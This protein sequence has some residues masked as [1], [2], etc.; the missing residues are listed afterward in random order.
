MSMIM[1]LI[2]IMI[3]MHNNKIIRKREGSKHERKGKKEFTEEIIILH[4][5]NENQDN[6]VE[7]IATMFELQFTYLFNILLKVNSKFDLKL[8]YRFCLN[9]WF[10]VA[11]I[12][13]ERN[14]GFSI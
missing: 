12:S 10:S 1:M 7:K 6:A 8:T 4:V 5:T 13:R 14:K 2:M 11:S 9:L 3:M